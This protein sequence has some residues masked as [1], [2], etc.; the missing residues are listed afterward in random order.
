[1]LGGGDVIVTDGLRSTPRSNGHCR[2]VSICPGITQV[3]GNS[4]TESIKVTFQR[5]N[6]W[7]LQT[8]LLR[9]LFVFFLFPHFNSSSLLS[10][11]VVKWSKQ[12]LE[13]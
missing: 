1:M 9:L 2:R 7:C 11:N 10:L 8:E 12:F 4:G 5:D 13:C 6:L 3:T